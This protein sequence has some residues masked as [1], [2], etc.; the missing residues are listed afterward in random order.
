MKTLQITDESLHNAYEKG[1]EEVKETLELLF[2]EEF[3]PEFDFLDF[4]SNPFKYIHIKRPD[5]IELSEELKKAFEKIK[6]PIP[7][8]LHPWVH[9]DTLTNLFSWFRDNLPKD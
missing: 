9:I 3:E 4:A 1:C 8:S 6:K 5:L 2:P 7:G